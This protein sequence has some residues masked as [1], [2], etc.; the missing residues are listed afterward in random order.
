LSK[1]RD[2]DYGDRF[3]PSFTDALAELL[4]TYCS[5]NFVLKL[6]P[7]LGSPTS[8][9]LVAG[10]GN[11]QVTIAING[12]W[13]YIT[14]T[15][16][17]AHP[18]GGAA[19]YDVFVIASDNVFTPTGGEPPED[20]ETDYSFD[21]KIVPVGNTPSGSGSEAL[22]RWVARTFW[23][24]SYI[25]FINPR[26][27]VVPPAGYHAN[28]GSNSFSDD[29][30]RIAASTVG[31]RGGAHRYAHADH[32]HGEP[33]VA[34][35]K[36]TINGTQSQPGDG[37]F[38][39]VG[40]ANPLAYSTDSNLAY[41]AG[42]GISGSLAGIYLVTALTRWATG[43]TA[44]LRKVQ[45]G[46]STGAPFT[47]AGESHVQGSVGVGNDAAQMTVGIAK[48]T[49]FS[50]FSCKVAQDSGSPIDLTACDLTVVRLG[51]T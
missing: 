9:E 41:S 39:T 35:A 45:V 7:N 20:D 10:P 6:I 11:D 18:T 12:K 8:I 38:R 15:I 21:L 26:V 2:F 3:H 28:D 33:I 49:S 46:S 48:I 23:T 36:A 25:E 13:R 29:P 32:T 51:L 42:V 16:T 19:S 17:K 5:P 30:V 50:T 4:G 34:A 1:H 47:I 44:G 31:V 43:G 40:I 14:S 37:A 24:G 27:G 22:Y